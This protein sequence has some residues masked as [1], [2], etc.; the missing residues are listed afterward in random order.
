MKTLTSILAGIVLIAQLS[1]QTNTVPVRLA[2]VSE[3]ASTREVADVLTAA[4]SRNDTVQLL[5]RAEIEQV[6]QEQQISLNNQDRLKLGQFLGADGLLAL[7]FLTEGTNQ[8]LSVQLVAVRP[9][10]LLADERFGHP[11]PELGGWTSNMVRLLEPLLPKLTVLPNDAIPI[12]VVNFH[13]GVRTTAAAELEQQICFLTVERLVR[14]KRLFI[15][16]RKRMHLLSEEKELARKET[17]PFWN[18]KYLLDGTIDRD[19]FNPDKISINARLIPPGGSPVSIEASGSRTNCTEVVNQ[20]AEKVLAMLKIDPS[21]T[22]WDSRSEADKFFKEAQWNLAWGLV[23]QA[24]ASIESAW[25]LGKQDEDCASLRIRSY[26]A[27]I[28]SGLPIFTGSRQVYFAPHDAEGK[29][30]IPS[31]DDASVNGDIEQMIHEHPD[32]I[33][34]IKKI[35]R[36]SIVVDYAYLNGPPDPEKLN[37]A[38]LALQLY[39]N[40][41]QMSCPAN[42]RTYAELQ[43]SS[44]YKL[45]VENLTTASEILKRFNFS[46]NARMANAGKLSEV[47]SLIRTIARWMADSPGVRACYF[48]GNRV[49]THDELAHTIGEG[50]NIFRCQLKWGCFWQEKPEDSIDLYRRLMESPVFCYLHKDLWNRELSQPRLIAWNTGDQRRISTIW[51]NF[52][53]ELSASSNLLLRMEAKALAW[54]D[55]ADDA[56]KKNRYEELMGM[57]RSNRSELVANKVELFYLDWG[58]PYPNPELEAMDDEYWKKTVNGIAARFN[59]SRVESVPLDRLNSAEMVKARSALV[60]K[61]GSYAAASMT[62]FSTFDDQKAYL[63]TNTSYT[64]GTFVRIFIFGFK[65]Y[66]REQAL[67]IKPLLVEYKKHLSGAMAGIGEIQVG[68]VEANIERIL[69]PDAIAYKPAN[70]MWGTN[71]SAPRPPGGNFQPGR[72]PAQQSP[73]SLPDSSRPGLPSRRQAELVSEAA[74]PAPEPLVSTNILIVREFYPMPMDDLSGN[75]PSGLEFS[76]H[77][78]VEGKLVLD[79]S[80][81]AFVYSFDR[82][83]NWASTLS[84]IFAGVAVFDPATR[85]W[86]VSSIPEPIGSR[87]S[88]IF[89]HQSTLWRGELY[90]S[91]N[92]KVQ[93]FNRKAKAW[94]T[95]ALPVHGDFQFWNLN[96]QLY[97]TDDKSIQQITEDGRGTRLLTSIQRQQPVSRLDSQGPLRNL[98]LFTDAKHS[99]YAAVHN[100]VFRWD[101]ADWQET[102]SAPA[103]V[104]PSVSD[105]GVLLSTD[106]FNKKP[107]QISHYD[108]RSNL[109]ELCLSQTAQ[110]PSRPGYVSRQSNADAAPNPLWKLPAELSL[111]NFSAA[112]WQGDLFLM[113]D[114]SMKTEI[115]NEREQPIVRMKFHPKDGYDTSIFCFARGLPAASK[116]RLQFEAKDGCPPM[117]GIKSQPGFFIP[118]IN[119]SRAWMQFTT[120]FLLCGRYSGSASFKPGVWVA[121]TDVIMSEVNALKTKQFNRQTAR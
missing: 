86:Q 6:I 76:D 54:S 19:G 75:V 83:G 30:I 27:E 103:S 105:E 9:G 113:A 15:L 55:A 84:T 107:A 102:G 82:N 92:G 35:E 18:G 78:L 66:T 64:P 50:P 85:R 33:V 87:L 49:A 88:K 22:V 7:Q 106:G 2:I 95:N 34:F 59:F 47:R 108:I 118:G 100:K 101:G 48:V 115:V 94:E 72:P 44:W 81:F 52:I 8:F 68:R 112:L 32:G 109:V 45:G 90:A 119:D 117:A 14:E 89:P 41:S 26:L 99:L 97:V 42:G 104:L 39:Q 20:L 71:A 73:V 53:V 91:S 31:M 13:A 98:A 16:E 40:F 56:A 37:R 77:Q 58:L 5:D 29:P 24:Q 80:Y 1:A 93:K 70:R 116:I 114:H 51:D 120:N 74:A 63:K 4:F 25:A 46:T 23:P 121:R 38:H 3:T 79:F 11:T 62:N 28:S 21:P 12:S 67:E 110:E 10:V 69:N 36:G 61:G 111:P 17:E 65:D 57:I 96:G 60:A 43:R